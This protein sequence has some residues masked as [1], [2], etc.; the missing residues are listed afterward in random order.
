MVVTYFDFYINAG[1][2]AII[3]LIL[4]IAFTLWS[5][6]IM[7]MILRSQAYGND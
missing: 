4:L 3:I 2:V 5:S 7:T 6:V 1:D